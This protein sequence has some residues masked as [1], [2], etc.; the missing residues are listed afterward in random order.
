MPEFDKSYWQNHWA[1]AKAGRDQSLPVNP[2]LPLETA[3]LAVG[4]VL[5]AGCGV[6]T[7]TLWLAEHGWRVT[8]ADI[9][10][11]ALST[12]RQR[13]TDAGLDNRIEWVETD[14]ARWEP[15]RRW[16]LVVTAYAHTD[17]GQLTF[18]R[19][20]SS[21]VAPGGTLLIVGHLHGHHGNGRHDHAHPD[22]ATAT[23]NAIAK[24][25]TDPLWRIDAGY[26]NVRTVHR[27]GKAVPLHDV[28]VRAHYGR[29]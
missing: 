27:H 21:W 10:S 20:L 16:D 2:Y 3:P 6:G 13:A 7:E 26:E 24:L 9:S 18:Y 23:P 1:P 17:T 25:F 5:D 14:L 19:R 11:T 15:E 8:A 22:E 12:A 4:S 28:V 29:P